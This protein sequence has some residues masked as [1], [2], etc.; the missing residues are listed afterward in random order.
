MIVRVKL[1][2]HLCGNIVWHGV[3]LIGLQ[4]A[5]G[6][7]QVGQYPCR[8]IELILMV[9][10]CAISRLFPSKPVVRQGLK[11]ERTVRLN[12]TVSLSELIWQRGEVFLRFEESLKLVCLL[13]VVT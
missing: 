9:L 8:I 6:N 7:G 11:E 13:G 2:S 10:D 4:D 3:L 1:C 12:D 5:S